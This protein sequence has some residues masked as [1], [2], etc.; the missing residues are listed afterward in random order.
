[1]NKTAIVILSDPKSGSEEALG[2]VFNALAA[3]YDFKTA[4]E[5][6]KIIFQGTATRWPEQL[7]KPE[8]PVNALYL[9]VEDKIEG[10]SS[11]CATVFAAN[12]SGFDLIKDNQVP[13]TTGLPSFIKL[14]NDGFNVLIF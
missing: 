12:P 13:G 5:E 8:H 4:E 2:R 3:A 11:G 7:Q 10:I 9:A 14:K 6:I 1:M